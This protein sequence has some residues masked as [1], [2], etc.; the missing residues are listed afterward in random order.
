[1]VSTGIVVVQGQTDTL[2]LGFFASFALLGVF[3]PL[4]RLAYATLL[5]AEALGWALY[6][7]DERAEH[8]LT[9]VRRWLLANWRLSGPAIGIALAVVFA[10]AGKPVLDFLL[11][12]DLRGLALPLLLFALIIPVRFYSFTQTVDIMRAGRQ[13]ARIPFL[14]ASMAVLAVGGV[15]G[16]KAGSLT[17]L[18]A[19][20]LGAE[21]LVALGYFYIAKGIRVR[22]AGAPDPAGLSVSA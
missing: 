11:G 3:G 5:V 1:M 13:R 4:F 8:G 6:S 19:A 2:V 22:S 7:T 12:R 18:A 16:A 9:G 17:A 15:V 14:V 20:R 21:S 10:A